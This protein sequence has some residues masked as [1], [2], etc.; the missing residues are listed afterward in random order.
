MADLGTDVLEPG[1]EGVGVAVAEGGPEVAAAQVME[2][3]GDRCQVPG[4]RTDGG[5]DSVGDRHGGRL[6]RRGT[7]N[8]ARMKDCQGQGVQLPTKFNKI[9]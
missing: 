9:K 1:K 8:R 7:G 5:D 3:I 6:P 4:G 2:D